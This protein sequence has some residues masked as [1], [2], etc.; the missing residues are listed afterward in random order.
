MKLY[1]LSTPGDNEK[2]SIILN[3]LDNTKTKYPG[4]DLVLF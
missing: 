2:I 3:T 1:T 4:T